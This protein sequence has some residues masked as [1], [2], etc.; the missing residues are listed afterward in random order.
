MN[1]V[2]SKHP[3]YSK[4]VGEI[5]Y[6]YDEAIKYLKSDLEETIAKRVKLNPGKRKKAG[7][8]VN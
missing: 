4:S 7:T 8:G 5:E 3:N 6:Y 1:K 2:L